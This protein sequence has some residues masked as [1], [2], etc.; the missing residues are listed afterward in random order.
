MNQEDYPLSDLDS[1]L[2]KD[3]V[4]EDDLLQL[5]ELLSEALKD[6]PSKTLLTH[7]PENLSFIPIEKSTIALN[8]RAK[9][10]KSTIPT[11]QLFQRQ[12]KSEEATLR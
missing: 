1:L 10:R 5:R 3:K 6:S 7:E 8:D 4:K 11:K 12:K 9:K 2:S